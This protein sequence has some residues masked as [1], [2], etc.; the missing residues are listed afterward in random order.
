MLESAPSITDRYENAR[1]AV[2]QTV[3]RLRDAA[4]AS[5]GAIVRPQVI[6]REN[7]L[8]FRGVVEAA[9]AAWGHWYGI[10][11][12]DARETEYIDSTG[13]GVLVGLS[14]QLRAA[15]HSVVIVGLNDELRTL[16]E[17]TKLD[18]LFDV[19]TASEW[20]DAVLE[21]EAL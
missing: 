21:G 2:V 16:F 13:M 18:V 5:P 1:T 20:R 9:V 14:R 15:G 10:V 4:M 6:V 17:L 11:I 8:D 19:R 7:R 3:I 12:V